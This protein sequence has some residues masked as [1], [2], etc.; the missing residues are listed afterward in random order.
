MAVPFD[1]ARLEVTG[2][3][4]GI[5]EGVVQAANIPSSVMDSG[6]AQFSFSETG[7]LLYVPGGIYPDREDSLVWVDREGAAEALVIP[8]GPYFA[9][10]LSPDG[11][12][13]AV[14]TGQSKQDIWVYDISRDTLTRLTCRAT[15]L[16]QAGPRMARASRSLPA[17]R[18]GTGICSGGLR[19][20]AP[21]LSGLRRVL[22]GRWLRLG[23]L[24]ERCWRLL[25]TSPPLSQALRATS[26]CSRSRGTAHHS[27][28]SKHR[29]QNPTRR[30]HLTGTGW[31]LHPMRQVEA[32]STSRRI[33]ALAAS[34]KFRTAGDF[35]RPGRRAGGSCFI[36]PWG[37]RT[38]PGR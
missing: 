24:T 28:F 37:G 25:C 9:P 4:V 19:T 23:H 36:V 30:F 5:V 8:K 38:R 32:R 35:L 31:P 26:G 14:F 16:F 6:A 11:R 2:G 34:T 13:I 12:R 27:L 33:P 21:R 3:P 20:S 7:S 17:A 1:L 15:T 22:M 29:S 10:R 18:E